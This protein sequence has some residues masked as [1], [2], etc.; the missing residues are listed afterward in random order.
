MK[1]VSDSLNQALFGG[2]LAP[3]RLKWH[4]DGPLGTTVDHT[5]SLHQDL[6][7]DRV[8]LSKVLVHELA[9]AYTWSETDNDHGR[10][11]RRAMWG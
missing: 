4:A 10:R 6:L 1:A 9:H 2:R 7:L 11:W 3:I 8:R 5:I